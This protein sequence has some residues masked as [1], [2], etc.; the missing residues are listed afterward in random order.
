MAKTHV[1]RPVIRIN[2]NLTQ[3]FSDR[4]MVVNKCKKVSIT[5]IHTL[6]GKFFYFLF[7]FKRIR[8]H[9]MD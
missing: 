5:E 9:L 6:I 3:N 1:I 7:Y 8:R 4:L 2:A